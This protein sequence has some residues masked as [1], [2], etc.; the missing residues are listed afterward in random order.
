MRVCST[1]L[2]LGTGLLLMALPVTAAAETLVLEG[3]TLYDGSGGAPVE[4]AVVVVEDGEIA[5]A[6]DAGACP[7]PD[8]AERHDLSGKWL[9][10]G[11]VDAHVHLWQTGFFDSRPDA[12]DLRDELPYME[13]QTRQRRDPDR[14]FDAWLCSGITA[15]FDVGG[16]PWSVDL[17]RGLDGGQEDP[18]LAATGPLITHA[19]R[20]IMNLPGEKVMIP[21]ESEEEAREAVRYVASLEADAAKLWFLPV[22][23]A[24]QQ[25]AID[26]RVAALAEAA[27]KHGIPLVTH[28]TS[29]REAKVAV[30]AGT[31][32][33]VHGVFDE[34]VDETFL[35]SA[36]EADV[37]Y[38]PT[39]IVTRGYLDTYRAMTGD[40]P[41]ELD[42]PHD[43]VDEDTRALLE[44]A[45][46]FADHEAVAQRD[47]E[48]QTAFEERIEAQEEN[49]ASNLAAV[50]EAGITVAAGTDAGN[51][52]TVHGPSIY[53]E[54]E[55]M[56]AAGIE[57]AELI[58]MATANGAQAMGREDFGI[59]EAGRKA[60]LIVLDA[61][62][63][64]DIGNLRE[65][66]GVM[67]GGQW[68]R[69][70]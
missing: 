13:G 33:L 25:E 20:E 66:S 19:P 59:V 49:M 62:P 22:A 21:M 43:C 48:W 30:E 63:G 11:L 36:R 57:P 65:M 45:D 64:E 37:V 34:E 51:P 46:R 3:A 16:Y 32:V 17:A 39:M 67:R 52:G 10:P 54:L 26:T 2:R 70:P 8:G 53:A 38:V 7:V 44:G 15:A 27:D 9:M 41:F 40:H 69:E 42:D 55:T 31:D 61:D 24:D 14:Y 68:F 56:Q 18:H 4:D 58:P 35:A 1:P 28:A 12:A 47:S 6:G 50:H 5:C 29:L 60:D 23:E